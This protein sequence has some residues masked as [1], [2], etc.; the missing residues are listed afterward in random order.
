MARE[1]KCR[2]I[3]P[4]TKAALIILLWHAFVSLLYYFI[5]D[6]S[7]MAII[8]SN[9][10]WDFSNIYLILTP[11]WT[12]AFLLALCYPLSG[13]I[14]DIKCGRF[15]VIRRSLFLLMFMPF[16]FMMFGVLFVLPSTV[17]KVGIEKIL[18]CRSIGLLHY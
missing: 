5:L 12:T 6:P 2:N 13:F 17:H 15:K 3:C 14:G 16:M 8:V 1:C 18:S 7:I 11:F 10:E 9:K 4:K